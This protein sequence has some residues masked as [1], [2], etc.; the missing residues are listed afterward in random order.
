MVGSQEQRLEHRLQ[1]VDLDQGCAALHAK[2]QP[3]AAWRVVTR[4]MPVVTRSESGPNAGH[5]ATVL[6]GCRR[7]SGVFGVALGNEAGVGADRAT[8]L[9]RTLDEVVPEPALVDESALV[10]CLDIGRDCHAASG[11]LTMLSCSP[12]RVSVKT[13]V[14]CAARSYD[15]DLEGLHAPPRVGAQDR[16]QACQV[17]EADSPQVEDDALQYGC[18]GEAIESLLD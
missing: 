18:S 15:H 7:W 16:P 2:E 1:V 6:V 5:A 12:T 8:P 10:V 3:A 13:A 4:C 11:S 17:E 14:G 9:A